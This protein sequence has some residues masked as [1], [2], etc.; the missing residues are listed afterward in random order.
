MDYATKYLNKIVKIKIDRPLGSQHP[1]YKDLYYEV[2]YGFVV[3]SKAPDGEEIDAYVLG[4]SK[5]IKEYMGKCVAVIHRTD[6]NDDKLVV[7]PEET[8]YTDEQIIALT[9]F[10]EKF[11][12][13]EIIRNA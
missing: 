4:V 5:P 3:N 13:S 2:N 10:Q 7:A 9:K 1:K 6:D 8:N 12:K 11:F